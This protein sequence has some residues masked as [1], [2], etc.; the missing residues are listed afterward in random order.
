M[1]AS[2]AAVG[3]AFGADRMVREYTE[4]Y[5]LPAHHRR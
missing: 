2:I 5:Y 4:G 1:A 3:A